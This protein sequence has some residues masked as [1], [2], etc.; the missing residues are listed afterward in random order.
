M[1]N[2]GLT[3]A[4]I[5]YTELETAL[6]WYLP[7]VMKDTPK[8][9]IC[10]TYDAA[11]RAEALRLAEQS[12]STQVAARALNIDPKRLYQCQ[13]P[14]KRQLRLHWGRPWTRPR[15]PNCATYG[16]CPGGR[17]GNWPF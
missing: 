17:R 15:P 1:R 8:P 2:T 11:F 12:C 9:D 13:R 5:L 10:R 7:S 14:P 3:I 6:G 4:A 16:P